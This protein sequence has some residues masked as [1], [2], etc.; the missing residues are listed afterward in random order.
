MVE[1]Y[2]RGKILFI[3]PIEN[4][5]LKGVTMCNALYSLKLPTVSLWLNV[6]K[7]SQ[8]KI[9]NNEYFRPGKHKG[10]QLYV[11]SILILLLQYIPHKQRLAAN[12]QRPGAP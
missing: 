1:A 6:A 4:D 5:R 3:V 10:G 8:N 11:T 9:K 7:K 2:R 12:Q